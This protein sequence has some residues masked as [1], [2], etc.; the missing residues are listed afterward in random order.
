MATKQ[1]SDYIKDLVLKKFGVFKEFKKWLATTGIVRT[2]GQIFKKSLN[3]VQINNRLT[4]AQASA[5][6]TEME[7]LQDVSY[8][9]AYDQEQIDEV[10]QLVN[11][12]KIE[13]NSWTF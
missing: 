2:N 1:Q 8:R 9:D 3:L 10:N 13:V 11:D 5:L 4:T 7:S 12:I 6:I